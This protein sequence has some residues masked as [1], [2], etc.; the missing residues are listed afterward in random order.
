MVKIYA[1]D[2]QAARAIGR[3]YLRKTK[4]EGN[5]D[6]LAQLIVKGDSTLRG[7]LHALSSDQIIGILRKSIRKDFETD[8]IVNVDGWILSKTEARLC[9]LCTLL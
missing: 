4:S 2:L 5:A 1:H 7:R 3:C 8:N 6:L 9:A